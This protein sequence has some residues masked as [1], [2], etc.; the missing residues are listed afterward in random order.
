[1]IQLVI[2]G[3]R[4]GKSRYGEARVAEF[5]AEG[6]ECIYLATAL[7]FD[8]EMRERIKRHQLDRS[9]ARQV[10]NQT[11]SQT[12]D[13]ASPPVNWQLIEQ[14]LYVAE[15]LL[16]LDKPNQTIFIDC[17]TLYL[18]QH[19]CRDA[20]QIN[21]VEPPLSAPLV[22]TSHDSAYPSLSSHWQE[23]KQRLLE[24]LPKL[25]SNVILISNEVGSGIVPMGELSREFVDEA[26]WLNQAVAAIADGVTLVVAG[27]PMTLKGQ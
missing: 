10:A 14:P 2:G 21:F 7:A 13:Q 25:Q 19:L 9:H 17:L 22:H 18:T 1:M 4:S 24:V 6:Q 3:A 27:I 26:G 20:E 11:A 23:Q 16:T 12:T 15:S 8:Q 5:S